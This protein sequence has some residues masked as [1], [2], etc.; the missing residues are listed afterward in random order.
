MN[1]KVYAE[2]NVFV[3]NDE[4]VQTVFYPHMQQTPTKLT[5]Q[6]LNSQNPFEMYCQWLV[7]K[8]VPFTVN[9]KNDFTGEMESYVENDGPAMVRELKEWKQQMEKQGFTL[10][11]CS[12]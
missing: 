10:S 5:E 9:Y 4:D 12:M 8:F 2:R 3:G 6:L 7:S 11:Y 1:F